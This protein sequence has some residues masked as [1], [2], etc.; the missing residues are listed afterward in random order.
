MWW[1]TT[2]KRPKN[3]PQTTTI[4]AQELR[5]AASSPFFL[6]AALN[7]MLY[8]LQGVLLPFLP[9]WYLSRGL[10]V[11][12]IAQLL[13]LV[14]LGKLVTNPI[15]AHV[16]DV[17]NRIHTVMFVLTIY[18]TIGYLAYYLV[19]SAQMTFLIAVLISVGMTSLYPLSETYT[20]AICGQASESASR[21]SFGQI[22]MWGSVGFGLA[23]LAAGA[24]FSERPIEGLLPATVAMLAV[25]AVVAALLP[26][27]PSH[28]GDHRGKR[29]AIP[30][31]AVMKNRTL[32]AIIIG[33]S[34]IQASNGFFYSFAAVYWAEN[35]ISP[36]MTGVLW[37][38][39]T[40]S[41]IAVFW[42][43]AALLRYTTARTLLYVCA[44]GT[45]V[46]WLTLGITTN[47]E[48]LVAAQLLQGLTIAGARSAF[49]ELAAVHTPAGALASAISLYTLLGAGLFTSA[50]IAIA[51]YLYSSLG[52]SGY[53]AMAVIA[54]LAIPI[55][56][57]GAGRDG[58]AGK[59]GEQ[60]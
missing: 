14:N 13:A 56:M 36:L 6:A 10:S 53:I 50:A 45:A 7:F 39:G 23:M 20:L 25:T 2:P 49:V 11:G 37:G 8:L 15:T 47:L 3:M 27:A 58:T 41:E 54:I 59:A 40:A 5:Q 60:N 24:Y 17:T 33:A 29:T 18:S 26:G 19:T 31:F 34:L 32:L 55:S 48:A 43:G 22:R 35:G 46:R 42:F 16:A 44:I 1:N 57:L 38:L 51:G 52:T 30:A 21:P 12:E 28:G 9:L 4:Q